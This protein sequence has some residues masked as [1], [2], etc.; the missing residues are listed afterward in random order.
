[1]TLQVHS[2]FHYS[3]IVRKHFVA[4]LS[5]FGRVCQQFQISADAFSSSTN[6][7]FSRA[8]HLLNFIV[9]GRQP[10]EVLT[11]PEEPLG[12]S[13]AER[14]GFYAAALKLTLNS[15]YTLI[16]K[17]GWRIHSSVCSRETLGGRV[18]SGYLF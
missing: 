18:I 5:K 15:R 11:F 2:V 10:K 4:E 3:M 9:F 7:T 14:G 13:V 8:L 17:L 1:M 6:L 12:L 16:G